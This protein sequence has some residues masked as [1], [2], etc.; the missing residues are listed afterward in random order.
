VNEF[1]GERVIPGEVNEDLWAEHVARYAFASRLADGKRCL[2]IGCGTGYGVGEFTQRATFSVGIDVASQAVFYA[3][4]HEHGVFLQASATALPFA[5]RSFDL[6]TAFEVIEHLA[7]WPALVSEARRVLHQDGVF[8]VSTPNKLYYAE[9]RADKGANPFH[10]HEFEFEEFQSALARQF[11]VV[12][13]LLQNRADCMVFSLPAAAEN[14]VNH[15]AYPADARIDGNGGPAEDANFFLAICSQTRTPDALSFLYAPRASNLLRERER[16]IRLLQDELTQNKQW[17][18]D[19]M[20]ERTK[21]MELHAGQKQQLEEHNRWALRLEKDLRNAQDRVVQV[22]HELETEQAAAAEVT[23]AYERKV[24][25]LEGESRRRA[26][27]ALDVE[28]RLTESLEAK[29]AE[30]AEA[31]RLLDAAEATVVERTVHGQQ[32]QERVEELEA[33]IQSVRESRWVRM[34]RRVGLGP[35]VEGG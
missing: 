11:P 26:E 23:A 31:V 21:L 17:L 2:D 6:I 8:L 35:R 19:V 30:L 27:W 15:A 18:G 9:S 1:T 25:E 4:A 29:L 22:Q 33:Q 34:G 10:I 32:L 16:H 28:K 12:T 14:P 5:D 7:D 3:R 24:R 20:S 13:V